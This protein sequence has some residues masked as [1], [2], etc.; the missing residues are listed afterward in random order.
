VGPNAKVISLLPEIAGKGDMRSD[1]MGCLMPF[2]VIPAA[3][4][5]EAA[6]NDGVPKIIIVLDGSSG[7]KLLVLMFPEISVAKIPSGNGFH[8]YRTIP[9]P[10]AVN[11]RGRIG[12]PIVILLTDASGV[13]VVIMRSLLMTNEM[14]E[15]TVL[16]DPLCRPITR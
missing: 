2:D 13:S 14:V 6:A 10:M 11:V 16:L 8:E 7:V 15:D 1:R 5:D 9:F 4:N 12:V 3:A